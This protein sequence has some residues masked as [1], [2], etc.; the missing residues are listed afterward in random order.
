MSNHGSGE[1]CS[2]DAGAGKVRIVFLD[3]DG[4]LNRYGGQ[5]GPILAHP[6]CVKHFNRIICDTDAKV[7]VIS[8]WRH[9]VLNGHMDRLGFEQMLRSHGIHCS[10]LD[11][12]GDNSD[13]LCV[14]GWQIRDWLSG[15]YDKIESWV[16][17]EDS[18]DKLMLTMPI[19]VTNGSIGL[20]KSDA[21]QAISLLMVNS[22]EHRIR[23]E[24]AEG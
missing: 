22:H 10:V 19:V 9:L 15:R 4:V 7:V 20:T 2:A 3:I 5:F 18:P 24:A 17:L 12:T 14:R 11:V 13:G 21:E 6:D 1:V 23:T 16:V 8:N